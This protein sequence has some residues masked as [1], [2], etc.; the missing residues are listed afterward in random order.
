[1]LCVLSSVAAH[2]GHHARHLVGDLR[3]MLGHA[4]ESPRH[5]AGQLAGL[6]WRT[7]LPSLLETARG[8]FRAGGI[9]V[10][11]SLLTP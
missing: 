4:R 11:H 8:D 1:V 6:P 10:H 7:R 2:R 5:A 9:A 3:K